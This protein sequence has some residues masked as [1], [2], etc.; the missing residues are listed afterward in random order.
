MALGFIFQQIKKVVT[1]RKL[2]WSVCVFLFILFQMALCP[3]GTI[4]NSFHLSFG[5]FIRGQTSKGAP[6]TQNTFSGF[7]PLASG[8]NKSLNMVSF[9][10]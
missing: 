6:G 1:F 8:R 5:H 9:M 3:V 7:P 4:V 2:I 10:R